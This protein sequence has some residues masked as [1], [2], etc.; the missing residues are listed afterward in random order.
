MS[1]VKFDHLGIIVDD[2]DAALAHFRRIFE[3][4][5]EDLIYERDYDD[6]NPDTG[7]IEVMHFCLFPVGEVYF[8]LV[9]PVSDG[10]V[11]KFLERT[12]GGV[13]HIGITSNDIKSEWKLHRE[14]GDEIGLVGDRPRV[15]QYDVSYWFLHPKKN[16][17]AMFEV[18]AF[19][20]K[21]Q[22]SDMT[23]VEAT[24]DWAQEA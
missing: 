4:R 17:G 10:P 14:L 12:G 15:D 7:E 11:K 19:W 21:T 5:D 9:E 8:E 6:V 3:F 23:P 16:Y 22:T 13:H 1:I 20:R 18:D 24:P 2:L